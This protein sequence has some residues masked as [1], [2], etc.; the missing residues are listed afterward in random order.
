[1]P[2]NHVVQQGEH[3]SSIASQFGFTDFSTIWNHADN[4][5]LKQ[6][7]GNPNVLLPGDTL[8]IPDCEAKEEAGD[9]T[10]RHTFRL[11]SKELKL[12]LVLEDAHEKP[13]A[14]TSCDLFLGGS[15]SSV[16]TDGKGKIEQRITPDV[17]NATLT[18]RGIDTPYRDDL[19]SLSIGALD[20][21]DVLTGQSA[22]LTNL[23]YFAGSPEREDD[24]QFQS[25]LQEFQCDEKLTVDGKPGPKT[26]AKLR[27]MHGC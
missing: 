26:Q 2:V 7:R 19:L 15:K 10:R 13:I 18:I 22:R 23:G 27:Q 9:T 6:Q 16:T 3:V 4:A 14:N 8:V 25:A 11:A 24:L 5:D 12:R 20:P 1:M 21:V 17:S